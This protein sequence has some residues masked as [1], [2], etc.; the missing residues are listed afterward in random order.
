[1]NDKTPSP[2]TVRLI[3]RILGARQT[4]REDVPE[5]I[6]SVSRAVAA[7]S[8][9]I[10]DPAAAR[11]ETAVV[12]P[13]TE[14]VVVHRAR[15]ARTRA[16]F[17][18]SATPSPVAEAP[19]LMRRAEMAS[20]VAEPKQAAAKTRAGLRGIVK[21]YDPKTR[22]GALRL[23]GHDDIAVDADALERA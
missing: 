20:A 6:S 11:H 19:R 16:V 4:K 18:P 8:G 3:A 12:R 9:A 23:P 22:A 7:L 1:M 13:D 10:A 14:A 15:R 17:A 2:E 21:W 5:L